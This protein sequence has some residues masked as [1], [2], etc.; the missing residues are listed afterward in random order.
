[1]YV[2][3]RVLDLMSCI[4][5]FVFRVFLAKKT[6]QKIRFGMKHEMCFFEFIS[7]FFY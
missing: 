4:L 2:R 5:G 6:P 3:I 1:M 7:A